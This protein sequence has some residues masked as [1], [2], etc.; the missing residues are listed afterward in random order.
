MFNPYWACRASDAV[1]N[2]IELGFD[3]T[4][5]E[6]NSIMHRFKKAFGVPYSISHNY[7]GRT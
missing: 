1:M 4:T 7:W 2:S 6:S 3:G 5:D